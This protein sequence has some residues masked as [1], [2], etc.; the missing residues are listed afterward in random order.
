MTYTG[1]FIADLCNLVL[2]RTPK[3]A[4][5][6]QYRPGLCGKCFNY[7]EHTVNLPDG[8]Y[9]MVDCLECAL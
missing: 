8:G 2:R 9:E 5:E 3:P 7:R 1:T 4:P 6:P